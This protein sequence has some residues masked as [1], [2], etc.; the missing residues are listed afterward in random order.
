[1][2]RDTQWLFQV[3]PITTQV[4]RIDLPLRAVPV[5]VHRL[6][7]CPEIGQGRSPDAFSLFD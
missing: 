7:G 3:D 6:P 1:M 5:D 4:T 2:V